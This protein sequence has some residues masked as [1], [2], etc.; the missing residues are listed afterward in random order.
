MQLPS[1]SEETK[2]FVRPLGDPSTWD[3][4]SPYFQAA[5]QYGT[6]SAADPSTMRPAA[7]IFPATVDDI[8]LAVKYASN[9][10]I[11]I[12][13]RSGGHSH[14]GASSCGGKNIQLDM[15]RSQVGKGWSVDLAASELTMGTGWRLGEVWVN[16]Q[17]NYRGFSTAG[18]FLSNGSCA[19]VGVG[20]HMHTGGVGP[21]SRLLGLFI[22]N[23]KAFTIVTADGQVRRVC[24]PIVP[25]PS[26][27]STELALHR[28]IWFAVLGGGPG[29]FGVVVD[30][31]VKLH[32]DKDYPESRASLRVYP[33]RQ[34]EGPK[35][36]EALARHVATVSDRQDLP[37]DYLLGFG[38]ASA[39]PKYATWTPLLKD[40]M[41]AA[42][43]TAQRLKGVLHA[44][45]LF[46]FLVFAVHLP[47]FV[48]ILFSIATVAV[49][50]KW[51]SHGGDI[52]TT[53]GM[54]SSFF[55]LVI[56]QAGWYNG[57]GNPSDYDAKVKRFFAE[58][59]A[60]AEPHL[61]QGILWRLLH[62]AMRVV[63]PSR[64]TPMSQIVKQF[65]F[66]G[67][68]EF[69]LAY[70]NQEFADVDHD[71]LK[72]NFPSAFLPSGPLHPRPEVCHHLLGRP[73]LSAP[74]AV[75]NAAIIWVGYY[76]GH[77]SV[78]YPRS[79]EMHGEPE[80]AFPFRARGVQLPIGVFYKPED[81]EASQLAH[82]F[83]S[84]AEERLVGSPQ[85][86][87]STVDARPPHAP[88]PLRFTKQSLDDSWVHFYDN[89][90]AYDRVQRLKQSV[91]PGNVFS[92][93][94]FN[95]RATPKGEQE[96]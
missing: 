4:D 79:G 34:K 62:G 59:D 82:A 39:D 9:N 19:G 51:N 83:A 81:G 55:P 35:L 57:S 93:S 66:F 43:S 16:L 1:F 67:E 61:P 5:Y 78:A 94:V 31:T 71:L 44:V 18:S 65:M 85:G 15:A 7:V 20:G 36:L 2:V 70:I 53:S 95:V 27:E 38:F 23:V 72:R 49:V 75:Q 90:A 30:V 32:W 21:M 88:Y 14:E 47:W 33:Y 8:V 41:L 64:H 3:A 69:D 46:P 50:T 52:N 42:R 40:A 86:L 87:F 96:C 76:G 63:S 10:G 68:R 84:D 12:A 29:S 54:N 17:S 13:V 60:V 6:T 73:M 25:K 45:V 89:R 77:H 37:R 48:S 80:T 28:E 91:D 56:V 11:S 92:A 26:S 22:D 58:L 24:K 74:P